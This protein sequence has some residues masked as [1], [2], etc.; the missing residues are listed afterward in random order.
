MGLRQKQTGQ[1][2]SRLSNAPDLAQ[3]YSGHSRSLEGT[4]QCHTRRIDR[5][6]DLQSLISVFARPIINLYSNTSVMSVG[7]KN[8]PTFRLVNSS[9]PSSYQPAG[10]GNT[11]QVG[12]RR[13]RARLLCAA[14]DI[15]SRAHSNAGLASGRLVRWFRTPAWLRVLCERSPQNYSPSSKIGTKA[16]HGVPGISRARKFTP[17][18]VNASAHP[19]RG[20]RHT[21]IQLLVDNAVASWGKKKITG[22][23]VKCAARAGAPENRHHVPASALIIRSNGLH[24]HVG[25]RIAFVSQAVHGSH[26]ICARCR[27]VAIRLP[28]RRS[29]Q[30]VR[31]RTD[32]PPGIRL[33][34][35]L[36]PGFGKL[37]PRDKLPGQ[38]RA[39]EAAGN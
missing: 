29:R 35:S 27:W 6:R 3:Q 12:P 31:P 7:T 18:R 36:T 25:P 9:H 14:T 5:Q 8:P 4:R 22:A 1:L 13:A 20:I 38:A 39:G 33:R 17:R 2:L 10:A 32:R 26:A 19:R 30:I 28:Y 37:A 34:V 11:A 16:Q 23:F 21:R 24:S 15:E